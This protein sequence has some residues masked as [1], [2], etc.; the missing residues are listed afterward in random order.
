[1]AIKSIGAALILGGCTA[2]GF[3]M[4]G[5]HRLSEAC[6]EDLIRVLDYMCNDLTY[7]ASSLPELLTR[8]GGCIRGPVSK[9]IQALGLSLINEAWEYPGACMDHLINREDSLPKETVRMLSLLGNNLGEFHMD[10]QLQ[11]LQQVR[12]ECVYTLET[13]RHGREQRLRSYQT[14]GICAGAA[15]AIVLL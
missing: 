12:E 8:A 11:G 10:G 3:Y 14:L 13:L 7:R 15:L 1:M 2:G 5:S 6:L 9:I 4:A